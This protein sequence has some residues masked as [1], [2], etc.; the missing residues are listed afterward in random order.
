M[1]ADLLS[2]VLF[3][4]LMSGTF[5]RVLSLEVT[6]SLIVAAQQAPNT[7]V[8]TE[9]MSSIRGVQQIVL[10][11]LGLLATVALVAVTTCLIRGDQPGVR[12][13]WGG[14]GNGGRGWN[15]NASLTFLIATIGFAILFAAVGAYE[16]NSLASVAGASARFEDIAKQVSSRPPPTCPINIPPTTSAPTAIVPSSAV[17]PVVKPSTKVVH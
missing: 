6:M 13:H 17:G 15:I 12:G 10:L 2:F 8:Y 11:G 9:A 5:R 7:Q 14:F 16:M 3:L 4:V 1:F